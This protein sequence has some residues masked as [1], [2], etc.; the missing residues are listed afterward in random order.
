MILFK[1]DDKT[2]D[3]SI[4]IQLNSEEDNLATIMYGYVKFLQ[5]I[6]Y[7]DVTIDKFLAENNSV[8][9]IFDRHYDALHGSRVNE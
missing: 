3:M 7:H 9:A 1:F 2:S 8:E 4:Q 6:G 5:A